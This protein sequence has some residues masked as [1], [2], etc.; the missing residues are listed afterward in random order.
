M[1][2]ATD[3]PLKIY[4][5]LSRRQDRRERCG[6]VFAALGWEVQRQAAVD[7]R[8]LKPGHGF[9]SA[10]RYAHA[11]STR[12]ILRRAALARAEAV[13]IM[14]DDIVVPPDLNARLAALA[15][16]EDWAVL[17]LGCQHHERPEPV[18][19]GVVR[20]RAPLDTHAW[21]VRAPYYNMVRRALAGQFWNEP[22]PLP[23]ADILLAELARR[24]PAYA[25]YPNL[26][27]Q[28]EEVSDLLGSYGGNYDPDGTVRC[29]RQVLPGLLAE[30]LGGTAWPQAAAEAR[31]PHAWFWPPS[32][33]RPAL[34][35]VPPAPPPEP[36]GAQDRIAFLFLTVAQHYNPQAW[37]DYWAAAPEQVKVY[38]HSK[39]RTGLEGWLAQAQI[40]EHLP[41]SW[42]GL[43]L[44]HA[45]L[46]LLR[47]AL[48]DERNRF[49]VFA[50]ESCIPIRPL[51]ELTSLLSRDG[52]SRFAFE[53]SGQL[54]ESHPRKLTHHLPAGGPIP[55]GQYRF[56]SQ[57][58]LLHREAAELLVANATLLEAL[59]GSIAPDEFAFGTFLHI[60]GYP[61]ESRVAPRDI[62]W[63]QWLSPWDAHPLSFHGISP[64]LAS[65]LTVSGCFFARKF[66]PGAA[67]PDAQNYPLHRGG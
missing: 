35:H 46:A 50:S 10:G 8:R 42:G 16:P 15:L 63:K 61:L 2:A 39:E 4:L 18:S 37:A 14:E 12:M 32:M 34:P 40:A 57:W 22:G 47:A 31:V 26:A 48:Q 43:S 52:R 5:N 56:H 44:V 51:P 28:Q 45:E 64:T 9:H 65:D 33:R 6:E 62:T 7:A 38:A 54:A 53:T 36:L 19:R 11:L 3:F 58:V 20:V 30:S 25:L 13:L 23:A 27:W 29:G 1:D 66:L 60:A 24:I 55:L 59:E 67:S 21:A 41:T 17:Y 49:F